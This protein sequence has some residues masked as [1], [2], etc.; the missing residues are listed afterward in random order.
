[1]GMNSRTV[2]M[3]VA[4][5]VLARELSLISAIA[6]G[7][8]ISS[9]MKYNKIHQRHLWNN[10]MDGN[11]V[12]WILPLQKILSVSTLCRTHSVLVCTLIFSRSWRE[13]EHVSLYIYRLPKPKQKAAKFERRMLFGLR[14]KINSFQH[15]IILGFLR[16]WHKP[17][18]A[19]KY[20]CTKRLVI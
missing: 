6:A 1:M 19:Q 3:I 11:N 9:H 16:L 4:W 13:Q 18:C 17:M 12:I 2:A 5:A 14:M 15:I 7:Q 10:D 20:G 8:L